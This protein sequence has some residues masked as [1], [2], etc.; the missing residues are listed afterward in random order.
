MNFSVKNKIFSLLVIV[1]VVSVSIVGW[2]GFISAKKS[3][4]DSTLDLENEK[5]KALSNSIEIYLKNIPNDLKYNSNFY[6][7]EKL[8]V[9][10]KLRDK[11]KIR[12]WNTIYISTLKDY[13][14]NQKLYYQVRILDKDGNEKVV[15]KYNQKTQSVSQ[16]NIEELQDKSHRNYFK[17]AI[18]LKKG[19]FYIS[20]MNLNV[21]HGKVEKPFVPVLRYSMPIIDRNNEKQGVLVLNFNADKILQI[22][23]NEKIESKSSKKYYLVNRDGEYMYAKDISKRWSKQLGSGYN[24]NNE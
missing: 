1:M 6:A 8:L 2:Y 16:N 18:D 11:R 3:Y 14:K 5:T 13:I 9:W 20:I 21:E 22:I 17:K 19:D 7:L 15:L 24:F 12:Y 10:E 23:D 4:I